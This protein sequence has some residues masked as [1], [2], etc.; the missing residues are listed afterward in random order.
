MQVEAAEFWGPE[1][2]LR[3]D[4]AIGDDDRSVGV[5]RAKLFERLRRLQ[6]GWREHGDA[7]PP[8]LNFHRRWLQLHAAPGGLCRAGV[9]GCDL[10]A[11]GHKL[12]QRRHRKFRRAHEDQAKRHF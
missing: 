12:Q 9:H 8:C 2:G 11:M 10:V 7:E 6:C 3:Q 4:H 1:D 5:V